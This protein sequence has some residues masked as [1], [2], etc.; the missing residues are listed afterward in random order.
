MLL[1]LEG[2]NARNIQ[3]W[4]CTNIM[5]TLQ[6]I[7]DGAQYDVWQTAGVAVRFQKL[8]CTCSDNPET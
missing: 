7:G 3:S 4:E 5:G 1:C 8:A 2:G 6:S